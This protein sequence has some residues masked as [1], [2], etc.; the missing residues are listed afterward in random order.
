MKTQPAGTYANTYAPFPGNCNFDQQ[1]NCW[2]WCWGSYGYATPRKHKLIRV[3]CQWFVSVRSFLHQGK[4]TTWWYDTT[5]ATCRATIWIFAEVQNLANF[6]HCGWQV[7]EALAVVAGLVPMA[8]V[9]PKPWQVAMGP[10]VAM[11]MAMVAPDMLPVRVVMVAMALDMAAVVLAM[12]VPLLAM[13]VPVLPMV[14]QDVVAINHMDKADLVHTSRAMVATADIKNYG[15]AGGGYGGNYGAGAGAYG[16]Y[17]YAGSQGLVIFKPKKTWQIYQRHVTFA[18]LQCSGCVSKQ[19]TISQWQEWLP[20]V[21][22][23]T[24][25]IQA[26]GLHRLHHPVVRWEYGWHGDISNS[27]EQRTDWISWFDIHW[28]H[29]II[30]CHWVSISI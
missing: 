24:E 30:E 16:N 18:R 13:V 4:Q 8:V 14:D 23:V 25:A 19:Q 17:G 9:V 26:P 5:D 29:W 7:M 10:T 20:M 3:A 2:F 27:N 21:D 1:K 22:I 28:L 15:G 6:C 11:A 12:V